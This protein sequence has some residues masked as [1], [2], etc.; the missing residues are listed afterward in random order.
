MGGGKGEGEERRGKRE[1]GRVEKQRRQGRK[2]MEKKKPIKNRTET[3]GGGGVTEGYLQS[4]NTVAA[5]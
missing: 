3:V 2:E 4:S 1:E 5:T